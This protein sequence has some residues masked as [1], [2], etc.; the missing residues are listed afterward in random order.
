MNATAGMTA[1]PARIPSARNHEAH[2]RAL[3]EEMKDW[4][5]EQATG[6]TELSEETVIDV[7]VWALRFTRVVE[8]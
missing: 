3:L 4:Y 6:S 8:Y 7:K 2:L 5:D 1:A